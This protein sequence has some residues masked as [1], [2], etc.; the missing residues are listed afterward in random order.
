LRLKFIVISL[1]LLCLLS[2]SCSSD[3]D[4]SLSSIV[5]PYRFNFV[6][7]ELGA[8]S[9]EIGQ[10]FSGDKEVSADQTETVIEYFSLAEQIK[11]LESEI[12]ADETSDLASLEAE[13][14]DLQEQRAALADD[15]ERII[16]SQIKEVL[17]EQGIFNPMYEYIRLK[18]SFPPL[19]FKL[20]KLPYLL[21]ISPRERID[22]IREIALKQDLTLEEIEA[23][24]EQVDEL[25][26]SSLVVELG[27]AGALYP[28]LVTNNASLQFTINAAVEEWLHQYLAFKPLGFLYILDLLGISRNYEIATMNETL[29]SMVSEE[30][31]AIVRQRYYPDYETNAQQEAE[32]EFDFNQE[33]REIRRTVDEYLAQGEIELAEEFM[34]E[35]RQY[36]AS[37]GYY[38]RKLNQ[39]YFAFHGAYADSPTSISPIG[40]ELTTLREQSASLKDFLNTVAAMTNRQE[41]IDSIE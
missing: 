15:V 4:S 32:P 36:L 41:L 24:E 40:V 39:A 25:G 28:T 13:L 12:A 26:V 35:K 16:A 27:G 2:V 31:G 21:V 22:S 3:F 14:N 17:A 5:K 11:S 9:H 20:D 18:V 38:I 37:M 30:I 29:A 6:K 7:W 33:M 8:I 19:N 34:E 23:I 10:W 1:L